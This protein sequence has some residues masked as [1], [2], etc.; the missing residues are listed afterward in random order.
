MGSR[1]SRCAAPATRSATADATTTPS[2]PWRRGSGG[3]DPL[4]ARP[5]WSPK[6]GTATVTRSRGPPAT[7]AASAAASDPHPPAP[8]TRTTGLGVTTA[9]AP[10]MNHGLA[11]HVVHAAL[12]TSHTGTE[13]NG[14]FVEVRAERSLA[15]AVDPCAPSTT[16]STACSAPSPGRHR[17]GGGVTLAGG[18]CTRSAAG[19]PTPFAS[20]ASSRVSPGVAL[21]GVE[22]LAGQLDA[23][24]IG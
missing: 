13:K 4:P 21:S 17:T 19:G 3:P 20:I 8:P 24:G 23:V 6:T 5:S 16:T 11:E 22:P 18:P 15:E 7:P 2:A 10:S 9:A 14:L 12:L 1:P